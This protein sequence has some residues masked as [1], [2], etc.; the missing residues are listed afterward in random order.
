[1]NQHILDLLKTE[2]LSADMRRLA[3]IIGMDKIKLVIAEFSSERLD[4]PGRRTLL[5]LHERY[6]QANLRTAEDGSDNRRQIAREL[7]TSVRYVELRMRQLTG[8]GQ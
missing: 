7:G 8:A 6:I 4:I 1:M 5:R 2:D 3:D